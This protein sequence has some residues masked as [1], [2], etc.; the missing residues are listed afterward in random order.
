LIAA[1]LCFSV[2][3]ACA[4]NRRRKQQP[5]EVQIK[6]APAHDVAVEGSRSRLAFD[7]DEDAS[8][9]GVQVCTAPDMPPSTS[10]P[11]VE[12]SAQVSEASA[13]RSEPSAVG[14]EQSRESALYAEASALRD[15]SV[16]TSSRRL[17]SSPSGRHLAAAGFSPLSPQSS[18]HSPSAIVLSKRAASKLSTI[19]R[20]EEP[21]QRS[22]RSEATTLTSELSRRSYIIPG[23]AP[24]KLA[25]AIDSVRLSKCSRASSA[26]SRSSQ[27]GS[28]TPSRPA[29]KLQCVE[30]AAVA[31]ARLARMVR[32]ADR[33]RTAPDVPTSSSHVLQDLFARDSEVPNAS[34]RVSE[35]TPM[36]ESSESPR[37]PGSPISG[38]SRP[39]RS[40]PKLSAACV[41]SARL[42]HASHSSHSS[43]ST[44]SPNRR[45]QPSRPAP[46]LKHGECAVLA[47]TRIS[48]LYAMHHQSSSAQSASAE[49]ASPSGTP[50]SPS[51]TPR[52]RVSHAKVDRAGPPPPPRLDSRKSAEIVRTA[53]GKHLALEVEGGEHVEAYRSKTHERPQSAETHRVEN[54]NQRARMNFATNVDASDMKDEGIAAGAALKAGYSRK[55]LLSGG[56]STEDLGVAPDEEEKPPARPPPPPESW[57]SSCFR[58]SSLNVA[59]G[60]TQPTLPTQQEETAQPPQQQASQAQQRFAR[61]RKLPSPRQ[62]AL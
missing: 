34:A 3:F 12:L 15:A 55:Q 6:P 41:A 30:T 42:S 19:V 31:T 27:R 40:P 43:S 50:R 60:V 5:K 48:H 13:L 20:A 37:S 17:L 33:H 35:S 62:G 58:S 59:G 16:S 29:P 23:R 22:V 28:I 14:S 51:G 47:S 61:P 46:K 1:L 52:S 38:L 21:S 26:P 39:G 2:G 54:M 11:Q 32:S 9:G 49:S 8:T 56:Y 45:V 25:A 24:P 4:S 7:V 36:P 10:G 44:G 57:H 18:L 53:S